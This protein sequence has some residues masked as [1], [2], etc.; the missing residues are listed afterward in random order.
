MHLSRRTFLTA[1]AALIAVPKRA[2]AAPF[3]LRAEPVTAQIL[4]PGDGTTQ[5]LGFNGSTPG[6]ELRFQQ[7]DTVDLRFENTIGEGSAIHWHGIRID[8]A[9]DGV[10]YLTQPLVEDGKGFDYRFALPD[11]GT[12][13]YHSHNR[14]WEQ[15]A[16]GLYGPLIVEERNPPEVDH[17]ITVMV[18]DWRIERS[19]EVIKD[20]G[21][22]H[23]FSHAG[24]LG[25]FAKVIPSVRT[26][27]RGDRVRLRLINVATARVFPL[28]IS[29]IA[30]KIVALDGM[31]LAETQ[32]IQAIMLAPAQRMDI[33]ADVSDMIKFAFPTRQEPYEMGEIAVEGE[34]PNPRG[35]DIA[36]LPNARIARPAAEPTKLLN[37][38]L[39][40]GAMGGQHEGDDIWSLNGVSGLQDAP[41]QRFALGETV[42]IRIT[43]D[44]AFP[45]G[46]H[47]HGHHFHEVAPDGSLGPFRDTTLLHR[48]QTRDIICVFDNPGRW[49]LHCHMLGHQARGMKTW[50]KVG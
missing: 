32:E 49:L 26:V 48:Q 33:I 41:W 20:F 34:N 39:Q 50:V 43:N 15:V 28:E 27:R 38:T 29:G 12:Y 36:N 17:D 42:R 47:L 25:T 45:H 1:S 37:L 40:G 35:D 3:V 46:I 23:D 8:N 19:G 24:R 11:A 44:T 13:W 30:G 22:R 31:S 5:M 16:R 21:N 6:P 14:S 9:M 18:D 7:G 2:L 10:P 4:P